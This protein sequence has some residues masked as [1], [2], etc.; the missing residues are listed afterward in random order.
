MEEQGLDLVALL[1]TYLYGEPE[2][3]GYWDTHLSDVLV[4]QEWAR[5]KNCSS[6]SPQLW[7][8]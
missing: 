4:D 6:S 1:K 3:G 2:A 5:V 8:N 7:G